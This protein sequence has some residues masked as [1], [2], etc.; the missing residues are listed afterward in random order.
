MKYQL[1]IKRTIKYVSSLPD[2][3]DKEFLLTLIKTRFSVGRDSEGEHESWFTTMSTRKFKL[4]RIF[5]DNYDK[6]S[7]LITELKLKEK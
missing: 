1:N 4:F 6:I 3:E 5:V 7:E 2:C